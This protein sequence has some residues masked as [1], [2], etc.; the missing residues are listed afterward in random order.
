MT[1]NAMHRH[2]LNHQ[3]IADQFGSIRQS[4]RA[5]V[6]QIQRSTLAKR[7]RHKVLDLGVG[8]GGFL[9]KLQH[10]LPLAELTGLDVSAD[11]L[12]RARQALTLT[13]IEASVAEVHRYVPQHSQDLV[14]AHFVN[15]YIPIRTLFS[16][17]NS[18]T[19]TSGYFSLI[20]TTYDSFPVAQRYLVDFIN[21][22]SLL[23]TV[24]GHYYKSMA[25]NITVASSECDLLNAF[26]EHGFDVLEHKRIRIPINLYDIDELALFGLD[27]T[28]FLNNL[29]VRVLPKPFILQRLTRLCDKI[30]TFPYRD[31]HIVDVVL[32][33]KK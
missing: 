24:V 12:A 19:R 33:R 11:M 25:K 13:T 18:L 16:V 7:A 1:L 8:D 10:A 14:L 30:F 9:K 32:A 4:H 22:G 26:P 2:E 31:T 21:E 15:A 5:A 6:D 27:G 23:S 17:A 3:T 29:S 28:W 20:T